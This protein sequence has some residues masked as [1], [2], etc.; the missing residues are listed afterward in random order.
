MEEI[1]NRFCRLGE[2]EPERKFIHVLEKINEKKDIPLP[3]KDRKG[4]NV[5]PGLSHKNLETRGES[6][7]VDSLIREKALRYG[8]DENLVR[9]VVEMESGG[10]PRAT[11]R[12]GA[13]GLMQ[14][15][16]STAEMLG[17]QDP[18]DPEQNLDGGIR[19]LKTL[20]ERYK[21]RED[22]SLA[23]YHSGPS[24]VDHYGGVP[25]HPMVNHYVK[26]VLAMIGRAREK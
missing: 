24:R 2:S 8:V 25:P 3:E 20:L 5:S 9:S 6:P 11:S 17:V 19:Y 23:A 1:R 13:M 26:C 16:P 4:G 14:L 15:M 10:N 18:Y 7:D 21:G 22:L 12:A